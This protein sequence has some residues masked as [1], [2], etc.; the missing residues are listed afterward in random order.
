MLRGMKQ[1]HDE[2]GMWSLSRLSRTKGVLRIVLWVVASRS[3]RFLLFVLAMMAYENG[4]A[5]S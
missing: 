5:K 2:E 4:P 3:F 1:T